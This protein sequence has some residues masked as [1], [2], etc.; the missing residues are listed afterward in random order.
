M[1]AQDLLRHSVNCYKCGK[2]VDERD[3]MPN[4][5]EY[6]GNDDGGDLCPECQTQEKDNG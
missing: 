6:G 3:C 2:L 1:N 5:K 4:T